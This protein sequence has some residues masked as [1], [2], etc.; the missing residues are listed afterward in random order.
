MSSPEL[1][2][3]FEVV[4]TVSAGAI[5][6][7]VAVPAFLGAARGLRADPLSL[8][9]VGRFLVALLGLEY[10]FL[11]SV[12][13]LLPASMEDTMHALNWK[14]L[15]VFIVATF[16]PFYVFAW[17]TFLQSEDRRW[18]AMVT[19]SVAY[20]FVGVVIVVNG[21]PPF[22][23][24]HAVE[25]SFVLLVAAISWLFGT[26]FSLLFDSTTQLGHRS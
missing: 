4:A 2:A 9:R 26:S 7:T 8:H 18:R 10:V 20:V 5:L 16:G 17:R 1:G 21:I 25:V 13:Q 14:M 12:S 3:Y 19:L 6:A 15:V 23:A 22:N 24:V 11:I